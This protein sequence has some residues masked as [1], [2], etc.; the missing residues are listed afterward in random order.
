MIQ[1]SNTHDSTYVHAYGSAQSFVSAESKRLREKE[2]THQIR[3]TKEWCQKTKTLDYNKA[4]SDYVRLTLCPL[5]EAREAPVKGKDPVNDCE[6]RAD[7]KGRYRCYRLSDEK[8]CRV[9]LYLSAA[10]LDETYSVRLEETPRDWK[11][12]QEDELEEQIEKEIKCVLTSTPGLNQNRILALVSHSRRKVRKRLNELVEDG[13]IECQSCVEKGVHIKRYFPLYFLNR[14]TQSES[15]RGG[16]I[17]PPLY[18]MR[19]RETRF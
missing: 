8:S 3:K 12:E 13:E 7:S 5:C 2:Y 15:M 4:R 9:R 10:R 19:R 18:G 17:F 11:I 1:D 14:K 16:S 6:S